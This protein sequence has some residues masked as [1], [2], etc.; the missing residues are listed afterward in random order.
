[1]KKFKT[2]ANDE[3]LYGF[4]PVFEAL[5]AKKRTIRKLFFADYLSNRLKQLTS[6]AESLGIDY[7]V[8][9]ALRI[10]SISNT[11]D[12]QGISAVVSPIPTF[13]DIESFLEENRLPSYDLNLL[14]ILDSILDPHNFG[15]I[16]RTAYCVGASCIVVAKDRAC[17]PTPTVSKISAGALEHLSICR[18]TNISNSIKILK[19]KGFWVAGMDLGEKTSSIFDL[20]VPDKVAI[21]IGNEKK[22]LRPLVS[23]HCDFLVSV[24]MLGQ[25]DSLNASVAAG[26]V[27]Y[28]ILRKRL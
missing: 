13:S 19:E 26:V 21:V 10:K 7:E 27:L 11:I 16:V 24:P 4:H 28:E 6:T 23:S 14:V 22:G 1:M 2:K 8:V 3:I 5:S 12:H 15:A 20:D 18:I 17:Y 9:R 25:L